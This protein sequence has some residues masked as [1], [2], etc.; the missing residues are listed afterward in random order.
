MSDV[1][2]TVAASG[3]TTPA[4]STKKSTDAKTTG[5]SFK[6]TLDKVAGHKYAEI[7]N[8]DRKGMFVNQSGNA[9][10]GDAFK[11]VERDG[12][13]FHIYGTGA[14]RVV[15]RAAKREADDN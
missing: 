11:L 12:R 1:V 2:T 5:K 9:R 8:G 4:T 13:S 6:E 3:G 7:K 14:D 15:I 10:D